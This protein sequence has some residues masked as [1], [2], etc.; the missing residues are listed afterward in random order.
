MPLSNPWLAGPS[1]GRDL[2]REQLEERIL[3]LLSTHNLAV[4]ATVNHDGS[5]TATTRSLFQARRFGQCV[6]K[7][8]CATSAYPWINVYVHYDG[9]H[10]TSGA[11]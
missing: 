4:I 9:S 6:I 10:Y 7:Y 8:G 1:P 2:P 3:N 11:S 5:P